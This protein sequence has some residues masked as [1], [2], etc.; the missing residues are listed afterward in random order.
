LE[1]LNS[2]FLKRLGKIDQSGYYNPYVK[3]IPMTRLEHSIGCYFL[4]NRFGASIE[5]QIAGLIHDVSHTAFSH[6]S[7]YVLADTGKDHTFQDDIFIDFVLKT[8]IPDILRR[9]NFDVDYILDEKNF[10]LQERDIPD[11]CA[12]RLD[13]SLR[14]FVTFGLLKKEKVLELI[15]DLVIINNEWVFK[16]LDSAQK[17]ADYFKILNDNHLC[18]INSAVMFQRASNYFKYALN[19]KYITEK[20]LHKTDDY[21]LD[22]INSYLNEDSELVILWDDMNN[23]YAF[24]ENKD[25]Y[26]SVIY[27]KSRVIN[28]KFL[29]GD[30]VLRISEVN[31][32]WEEITKEALEPVKYYLKLYVKEN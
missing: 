29:K 4:L 1:L 19:K 13:Y 11:L 27:L 21:V 31:S 3:H 17:Y 8:D 23:K 28:P 20:D 7:D 12:D 14:S 16:S 2:P 15:N 18:G 10:P 5:E 6:F 30:A 24:E 22:K 9:Y 26:D 32:K 25:D